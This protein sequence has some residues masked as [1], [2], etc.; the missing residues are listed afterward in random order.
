MNE[1][2]DIEEFD[3]TDLIDLDP[4]F[5]LKRSEI[6]IPNSFDWRDLGA[7]TRVK[8][9]GLCGS[10]YAFAAIHAIESQL[11]IT[12]NKSFEFSTQELLD[13]AE[14]HGTKHCLGGVTDGVFSYINLKGGISLEKNYPYKGTQGLCKENEKIN[15]KIKG[16]FLL[17]N[18]NE[19]TL[20]KALYLHGPIIV[21]FD[22]LY[23]LFIKY[24]NGIYFDDECSNSQF[25]HAALIVGYGSEGELDYWTV[26]NSWGEKWGEKGYFRIA[27]NKNYHCGIGKF[28]QIPILG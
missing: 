16:Y 2:I 10:C 17:E 5:I 6:E 1:P 27:R 7:V 14:S 3:F 26:K 21:L 18:E 12:Q 4:D 19:E 23:D 22:C 25:T 20:K 8:N 15:L 13:C 11:L 24:S 9:Q 28:G